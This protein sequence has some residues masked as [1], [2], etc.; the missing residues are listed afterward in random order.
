VTIAAVAFGSVP[1][2]GALFGFT[3]TSGNT[4]LVA[5]L[6]IALAAVINLT[7]V[8]N[9]ARIALFGVVAE[10]LGTIVFGIIFLAKEHHH[11]LGAIFHTAGA[12]SGG[13]AG[14]FLAAALFSVWIFYGFE[15]CGDV[16]EEVVNPSRRIPRAMQLTLIVGGVTAFFITVSYVLAVRAS[17]T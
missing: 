4:K 3:V 5:I 9:L 7:G 12:G 8:R 14:A 15:A 10:V 11:G 1:Y 17:A 16:A 6:M 13:Y 2:V